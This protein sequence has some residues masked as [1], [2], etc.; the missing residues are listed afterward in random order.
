MAIVILFFSHTF[1]QE[2]KIEIEGVVVLADS[3]NEMPK[4][5]TIRFNPALHDFEGWDGSQWKSLAR[6][7]E[8]GGGVT[9]IG[10]NF[11]PTIK[12]G[13]QEWMAENLCTDKYNDSTSIPQITSNV[14]WSTLTVGA[15]S[16]YDNDPSNESIY[17]KLYNWYA[18][19]TSKLCPIGWHV[20][21]EADW[22]NLMDYLGG[23]ATAGGK[24]K[25]VGN[26]HWLAPNTGA[27]NASDITA[28]PHGFR[29]ASGQFFSLGKGAS[30][31]SYTEDGLNHAFR[32]LVNTMM[33]M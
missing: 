30:F 5:G 8:P 16:L 19:K 23:E 1:A 9:D 12:L 10:G 17:G 29:F 13:Q 27:T 31:W 14:D 3:D 33:L 7:T 2:E 25:E 22:D 11:Y 24:M 18:V 20:P 6:L 26:A 15:W 32:S 4:K 28:L 21:D